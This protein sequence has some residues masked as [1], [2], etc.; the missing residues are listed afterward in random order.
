[1]H[2]YLKKGRIRIIEQNV[3]VKKQLNRIKKLEADEVQHLKILNRLMHENQYLLERGVYWRRKA[4][5][6][7]A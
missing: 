7:D 5:E 1:M 3:F 2:D 6:P 4:E